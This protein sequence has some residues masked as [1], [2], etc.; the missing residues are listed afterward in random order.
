MAS[1]APV[2]GVAPDAFSEKKRDDSQNNLET[3]SIEPA[4]VVYTQDDDE[5]DGSVEINYHTLNW[6]YVHPTIRPAAEH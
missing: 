4:P 3:G 5:K 2:T 1:N 6:W